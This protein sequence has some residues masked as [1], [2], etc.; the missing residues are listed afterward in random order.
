MTLKSSIEISNTLHLPTFTALFSSII[1]FGNISKDR[2]VLTS[3][4]SDSGFDATVYKE[5]SGIKFSS[6][7]TAEILKKRRKLPYKA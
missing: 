4:G 3:L 2:C 5:S 1:E 7:V 6:S